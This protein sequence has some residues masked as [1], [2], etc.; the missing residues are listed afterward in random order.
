MIIGYWLLVIGYWLLVI[1]YW[2]LV[3]GYWLASSSRNLRTVI[4]RNRTMKIKKSNM[5][6]KGEELGK[7]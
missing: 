2:L 4:A 7:F 3:I 5:F 6:K 1:G